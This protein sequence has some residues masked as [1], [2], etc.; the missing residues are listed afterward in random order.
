[1]RSSIKSFLL[2]AIIF[3]CCSGYGC[4]PISKDMFLL[5]NNNRSGDSSGQH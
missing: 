4:F 1:M 3:F 5:L 2:F